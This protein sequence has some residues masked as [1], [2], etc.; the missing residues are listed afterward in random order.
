[1]DAGKLSAMVGQLRLAAVCRWEAI[2]VQT[3]NT[4]VFV[5][6]YHHLHD[7]QHQYHC[8]SCHHHSCIIRH[9]LYTNTVILSVPQW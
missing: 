9:P 6:I 5:T 8:C 7:H 4:R 2:A 1:M 3:M